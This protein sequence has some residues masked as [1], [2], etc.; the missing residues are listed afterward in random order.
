MCRQNWAMASTRQLYYR[1]WYHLGEWARRERNPDWLCWGSEK[2]KAIRGN[3]NTQGDKMVI[4]GLSLWLHW[5]ATVH[6]LLC[7]NHLADDLSLT[8][9]EPLTSVFQLNPKLYSEWIFTQSAAITEDIWTEPVRYEA[10]HQKEMHHADPDGRRLYI[11][12]TKTLIVERG[13]GI[14]DS[15]HTEMGYSTER[16]KRPPLPR[17]HS[18]ISIRHSLRQETTTVYQHK[19]HY[20]CVFY[21]SPPLTHSKS[22]NENRGRESS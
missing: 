10:R 11:Y 1:V 9:Q 20:W 12:I 7:L 13:L 5:L 15:T 16:L 3:D 22:V 8:S 19:F 6:D 18:H 4:N 14:S 17:D 21:L 2:L